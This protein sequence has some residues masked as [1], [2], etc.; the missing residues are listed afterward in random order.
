MIIE[1][2]ILCEK[3]FWEKTFHQKELIVILFR[4]NTNLIQGL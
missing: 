4:I 1:D 2:K 3:P